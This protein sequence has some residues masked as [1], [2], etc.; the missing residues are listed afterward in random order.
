MFYHRIADDK[1]PV[2]THSNRLFRK[3][4]EWLEK[5][6]AAPSPDD[7]RKRQSMQ[8]YLELLKDRAKQPQLGCRLVSKLTSTEAVL[9]PM[10][11]DAI[12]FRGYGLIVQVNGHSS[13]FRDKR[14]LTPSPGHRSG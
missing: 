10:M 13:F 12:H 1:A 6:L 2:G 14:C 11:T 9:K 5:Y 3:Q 4:I 8:S 7:E